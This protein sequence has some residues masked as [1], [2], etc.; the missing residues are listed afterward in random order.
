[1][2]TSAS[3]FNHLFLYDKIVSHNFVEN[4]SYFSELFILKKNI[5]QK[6]LSTHRLHEPRRYT[7]VVALAV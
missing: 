7:A 1:M 4:S 6:K 2:G 5:L 3:V